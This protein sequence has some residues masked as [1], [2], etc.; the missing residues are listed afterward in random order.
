[1]LRYAFVLIVL[2]LITRQA[3]ADESLLRLATT[4]STA[5]SG[6]M[7]FLLPKFT[8]K[9]AIEVHLIAV[10]TGKALRLGREGDVDVVLVHART[11]EDAFVEGRYGVD[12]TDVM[13][14]DFI[15]VGPRS[16]P[17]GV[18]D[19]ITVAQVLQR[20][21]TSEQPFVSRG[22]DSGT[23]KREL[24][25]WQSAGKTPAGNWYRE[26]GQ[27]MGK[28]LQI[29]NEI[30]G[31]TM[32]DR[33]TWLAYQ[34]KLD[35]KLLF[36]D[37]PPLFNPYGIIAVNPERHPDVNYAGAIRLIEWITSPT[38][39][40]MIGEFKIRGQQLFVPSAGNDS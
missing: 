6:L 1:M 2:L 20:I 32:T 29:A 34:S 33:G 17:A 27:G 18:A 13:Y 16:D 9:T 30:D 10:G 22:D 38:V 24:I 3:I 25:L 14:N 39:Q 36:E 28:T 21:N 7:E 5:N 15:I 19:S 40:K 31:Y 11:A 37:D 35:I 4:T 12:R 26:V 8:E 23:H